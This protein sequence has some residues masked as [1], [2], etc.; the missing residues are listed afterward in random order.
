MRFNINTDAAVQFSNTLEKLGKSALPNAVRGTLNRA[1]FDVKKNTLQDSAD[2]KFVKRQANFFKANSRFENAKGTNL[3]SMKATI[4]MVA[5]N[6]KGQNN[7]AVKDLEQQEEGGTIHK[8][9]FIPTLLARKGKSS[10]GM[11]RANARLS[12]IKK[13]I[14]ASGSVGKNASQQ[15]VKAAMYTGKGGFLLSKNILFSIDAPPQRGTTLKKAVIKRTAIYSFKKSR[16]VNVTPKYFMKN[17]SLKTG[18]KLQFFYE[19]EAKRQLKKY[20]K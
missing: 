9:S 14:K 10:R 17:A 5:T 13:I 1:V 16:S 12:E 20:M 15:Y 18:S 4:G 2:K 6:L 7:Y 8:K 19:E 11:V 3:S